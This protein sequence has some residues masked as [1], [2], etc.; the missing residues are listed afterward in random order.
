MSKDVLNVVK[1]KTG[2]SVSP[3]DI[4]R[5]ASGVKPSTL[6]SETQLRQLIK[7][8]SGLVNVKVSEETIND[9]IQAVKSSKLDSNNMQQLMNMMMGKK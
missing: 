5:I 7:Q 9:I 1:K 2:K 4:E 6:Q 3:K 8:V